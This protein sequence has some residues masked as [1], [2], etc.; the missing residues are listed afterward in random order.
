MTKMVGKIR[1]GF[2]CQQVVKNRNLIIVSLFLA[3]LC[4]MITYPGIL[5]TDSYSRVSRAYDIKKQF[6]NAFAGQQVTLSDG[7]LQSG[8]TAN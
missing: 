4:V 2:Y 1:N 6:Q 8:V 3:I 7:E 5:Y